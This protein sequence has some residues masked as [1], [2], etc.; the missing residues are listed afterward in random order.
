V[1]PFI[2]VRRQ[3]FSPT[4]AAVV[5]FFDVPYSRMRYASLALVAVDHPVDGAQFG[6]L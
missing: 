3:I 1:C 4:A 5:L 6:L 2:P